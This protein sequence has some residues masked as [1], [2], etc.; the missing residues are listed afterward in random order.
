MNRLQ[1]KIN[2]AIPLI[3]T[4]LKVKTA[5]RCNLNAATNIEE[6]SGSEKLPRCTHLSPIGSSSKQL[7]FGKSQGSSNFRT[8][9]GVSNAANSAQQALLVSVSP[10]ISDEPCTG[11]K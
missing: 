6:K 5:K 4:E 1:G 9:S 10:E 3:I 8:T 7:I 11:R 2:I